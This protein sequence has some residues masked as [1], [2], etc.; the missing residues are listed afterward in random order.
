M[1]SLRHLKDKGKGKKGDI[2]VEGE[3]KE[4]VFNPDKDPDK[5]PNDKDPDKD[6]DKGD[7]DPEGDDN[8]GDDGDD[9]SGDDDSGDDNSGDYKIFVKHPDGKTITLEVEADTTINNTKVITKNMEGIPTK[10]QRLIFMDLQLEDGCT[11]SDYDIQK[12]STLHLT[13]TLRGGGKNSINLVK[14]TMMKIGRESVKKQHT[15]VALETMKSLSSL[16]ST[17]TA[18]IVAL[19]RR[20]QNF[21]EKADDDPRKALQDEVG[22]MTPADIANLTNTI[23]SKKMTNT[24]HYL[25]SISPELFGNEGRQVREIKKASSF[26]LEASTACVRYA[27]SK[28]N[29]TMKDFRLLLKLHDEF[30]FFVFGFQG[31][32]NQTP[33]QNKDQTMTPARATPE[34]SG[35]TPEMSGSTSDFSGPIPDFS[36]FG[37]CCKSTSVLTAFDM[38]PEISG[39]IPDFLGLTPNFYGSTP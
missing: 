4:V 9:N 29:L 32:R 22:K 18:S 26:A 23:N 13:M 20:L 15:E 17:S 39:P 38:T 28:G 21:W 37:L 11:I 8:S 7:D 25:E 3:Q 16:G 5:D 10:Q 6:P 34:I 27:F 1:A 2:E 36:G 35:P 31:I 19:S 24:A 12:E 33:P 30:V 14:Q